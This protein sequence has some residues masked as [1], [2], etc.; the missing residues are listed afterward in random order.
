MSA[1][2]L[3]ARHDVPV[4]L[5]W[6]LT[7]I[8]ATEQDWEADLVRFAEYPEKLAAYKGRLRRSG[9]ILYEFIQL[10]EECGKLAAK[11]FQ[12]AH[13]HADE[14]TANSH[15]NGMEKRFKNVAVKVS[16]AGSFY[17]PE[18]L[19][20]KPARLEKLI[21]STPALHD[22]KR[23]FDELAKERAHVRSAE[24]EELLC[25][26][27]EITSSPQTIFG[28]LNN[29]DIKLP[30]VTGEDA[31]PTQLTNGSWA[32]LIA[33]DN[34]EVRREAFEA[35][36]G[37]YNGLRNTLA[38]SYAGQVAVDIF[39]TRAR[40]YPSCIDRAL[41]GNNI[42]VSVYDNLI[43]TVH[44]NLP[45]LHRSL[46]LRKRLLGV[47]ELQWY[48]L[49]VPMVGGVDN[50]ICFADAKETVLQALAPL[51]DEYIAA[52]RKGFESRWIDVVETKGK[53]NGAYHSPAWGTNPFMLLNW[54]AN[55]ESMFTLAHEGGHALHTF[56]AQLAQA[57]RNAG[58]TI[59]LA[60]VASTTNE[61]LLAHFLLQRTSDP[62]MRL[63]IINKMMEQVRLTLVRQTL[64]AEFDRQT[65][66]MAEAGKPLTPDALCKLYLALNEKYYGAVCKIDPI[67]GIEW[68]RIPHFYNSFYVYQYST[69]IAAACVFAKKILEEGAPAA[70]RYIDKFLKAGGSDYSINI[71]QA[72]GV[73]MSTPAP[74][75]AAFDMFAQYLRMFEEEHARLES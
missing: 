10:Q 43:A 8:Y 54:Q 49:Y 42:P 13:L 63:Y 44:A 38:A 32:T 59:F 53:R 56:F 74:I 22:Y 7:T 39:R 50:K 30:L 27:A 70:K 48:D 62:K 5:T 16:S 71:L 66:A 24:V 4:E 1:T 60:E 17:T 45:L 12:Y 73:D 36:F 14:D 11:L 15:Y 61:Q 23:D 35:M 6:D 33:S 31:H 19:A 9:R 41:S 37:Y 25:S 46:E 69:G 52:M 28:Q 29:A 65:H 18:V 3:P 40:H 58:Y 21:A 55:I 57:Y 34:R 47:D 72:A 51:G 67:I 2:T 26:C 20:I 64:F 68:A 75:Q